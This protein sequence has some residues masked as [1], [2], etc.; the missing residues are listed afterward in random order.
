[1]KN[2]NTNKTLEIFDIQTILTANKTKIIISNIYVLDSI[3]ELKGQTAMKNCFSITTLPYQR[4]LKTKSM[5]TFYTFKSILQHVNKN[6]VVKYRFKITL[7]HSR[8]ALEHK[9]NAK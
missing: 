3:F 5:Q 9:Q 2:I 6:N 8:E 7:I 4:Q 1:M